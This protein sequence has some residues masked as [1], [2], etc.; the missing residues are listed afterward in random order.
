MSTPA[1][2]VR[3]APAGA[4]STTKLSQTAAPRAFGAD[5]TNN[6]NNNNNNLAASRSPTPPPRPAVAVA[7]CG[8]D[9]PATS[10]MVA[11]VRPPRRRSRDAA[12]SS[13]TTGVVT[14][15]TSAVVNH[16]V[17][18]ADDAELP[19]HTTVDGSDAILAERA[20]FLR[21]IYGEDD[22][23]SDESGR[24][25]DEHL[26]PPPAMSRPVDVPTMTV[27][28]HPRAVASAMSDDLA[29]GGPPLVASVDAAD[30]GI[31]LIGGMT[32]DALMLPPL[33]EIP[34]AT[35]DSSVLSH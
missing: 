10:G 8:V 35:S 1:Q 6:N 22:D 14:P 27:V 18:D 13:A 28:L 33:P 4:A 15:A 32:L 3:S 23:A 16:R 2:Q 5:V 24:D 26:Q 7:A 31:T 21:Q 25:A 20:T 19:P 34:V 30:A 9:A 12:S 17:V 11:P 29:Y